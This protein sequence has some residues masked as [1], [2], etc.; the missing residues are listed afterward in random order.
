V[1]FFQPGT[2][3]DI[4]AVT[5]GFGAVFTDV[6]RPSGNGPG[7]KNAPRKGSTLI[8]YFD[9]NHKLLFSSLVPAAPG[10]AGLSFL[11]IVFA[12]ARIARVRITTGDRAPGAD[13][14]LK[15]IVMMDDFLYGEPQAIQ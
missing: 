11:G 13:D 1:E 6:D 7:G 5:T 8:E 3:T 9:Q 2:G 15:D 10:D 4:P 14:T 12:D